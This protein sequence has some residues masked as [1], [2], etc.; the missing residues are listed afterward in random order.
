MVTW[1][2]WIR[3]NGSSSRVARSWLCKGLNLG[4]WCPR[5]PHHTHRRFTLSRR[6]RRLMRTWRLSPMLELPWQRVGRCPRRQPH[7]CLL[8]DSHRLYDC[9]VHVL[10][11]KSQPGHIH[12]QEGS[13]CAT[14][15]N[16]KRRPGVRGQKKRLHGW[17]WRRFLCSLVLI[18]VEML[19]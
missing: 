17:R 6:R 12:I 8:R 14:D 13:A 9:A 16:K 5:R 2:A 3:V 11:A 18:C 7:L 1:M 10:S 4:A 19:L 15:P